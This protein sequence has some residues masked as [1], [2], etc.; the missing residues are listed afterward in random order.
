MD[1]WKL[2]FK[3]GTELTEEQA[4]YWDNVPDKEIKH[5]SFAL[6]NGSKLI[7]EKFTSICIAKLG[8]FSMSGEN[9]HLG[10]RI[11][12]TKDDEY[13]DFEITPQGV[14]RTIGKVSQL[15]VPERCFRSGMK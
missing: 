8:V 1:N 14:T 10:Y 5:A 3:D 15:T 12:E 2:L 11:I 9:S 4:G 7:F 13:V 6:L